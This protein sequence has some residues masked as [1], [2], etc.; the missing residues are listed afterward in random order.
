ML[1]SKKYIYIYIWTVSGSNFLKW[2]NILGWLKGKITQLFEKQKQQINVTLK[3]TW[4]VLLN[5]NWIRR[6][7]NKNKNKNCALNFFYA[8]RNSYFSQWKRKS[9][10]KCIFIPASV[11]FCLLF[12][13]LFLS[14][15]LSYLTQYDGNRSHC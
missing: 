10:Q 1:S 15:S 7:T 3:S 11:V 6:I 8:L 13:F 14:F 2:V 9:K 4:H 12:K 5:A